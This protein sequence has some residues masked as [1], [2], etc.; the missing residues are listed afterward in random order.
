MPLTKYVLLVAMF[1]L[2]N[3]NQLFILFSLYL[4][5]ISSVM[6]DIDY[7]SILENFEIIPVNKLNSFS[8]LFPRNNTVIKSLHYWYSSTFQHM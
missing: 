7:I 3:I 4:S 5:E 8:E 6:C 1:C 2:H